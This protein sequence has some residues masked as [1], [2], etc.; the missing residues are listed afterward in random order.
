MKKDPAILVVD[1]DPAVRANIADILED[2]GYETCSASSAEE[3]LEVARTRALR[4]AV[5]DL[6]MPGR[7]G[8]WLIAQLRRARP[9]LPAIVVTAFA[10][11]EAER[12]LRS[13]GVRRLLHKPL[14]VDRLVE[15]VAEAG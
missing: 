10:S 14:D 15:C 3:A 4:L 1:D 8:L 5:V 9:G 12:E 6:R 2:L 13:L 11:G 7:D